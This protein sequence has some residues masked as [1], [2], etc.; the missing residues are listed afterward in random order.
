MDAQLIIDEPASGAW[1][2]AVD[3]ALLRWADESG[4]VALRFYQWAKPTLSLGYF[5]KYSDRQTHVASDALPVVRRAT[6][7]GAILH[8]QELTYSFVAPIRDRFGGSGRQFVSLFHKSLIAVLADRQVKARLCGATALEDPAPFLCFRRRDALDVVIAEH[9]VAGSAQRRHKRALL[10][11]GS[12]LL[13][14]SRQVPQ[15]PGI[16]DLSS[17]PIAAATL[18]DAWTLRL[19]D[20]LAANFSPSSL[21]ERQQAWAVD[22]HDQRFG[23]RVWTE[24]R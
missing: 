10:Q 22:F 3:E 20:G 16:L 13:A 19:A 18:T 5:Q 21:T 24:R 14:K 4:G 7:G 1:N 11:H 15:L 12:V 8:D 6:G 17:A 23:D 9:K 2:M